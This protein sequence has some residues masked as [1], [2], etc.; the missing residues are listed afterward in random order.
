[1][2]KLYAGTKVISQLGPHGTM[3]SHMDLQTYI[4]TEVYKT[5]LDI[6]AD[7]THC[8]VIESVAADAVRAAD[9]LIAALN[10]N[11]T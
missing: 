10:K 8:A 3:S 2:E 4:A 6:N 9:V 1:M 5:L 11:R 7:K